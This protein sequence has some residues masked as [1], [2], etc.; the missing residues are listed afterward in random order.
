MIGVNLAYPDDDFADTQSN[1]CGL[2]V[3]SLYLIYVEM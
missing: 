3:N 2:E 1:F